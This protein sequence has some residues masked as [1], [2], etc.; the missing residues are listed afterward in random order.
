MGINGPGSACGDDF[1]GRARFTGCGGEG[2]RSEPGFCRRVGR[3]Q[4]AAEERTLKRTSSPCSIRV[5]SLCRDF[6]SAFKLNRPIKK[7]CL[8]FF[9]SGEYDASWACSSKSMAIGSVSR[10]GEHAFSAR[11]QSQR[12]TTPAISGTAP[13]NRACLFRRA[14]HAKKSRRRALRV[15]GRDPICNP[16]QRS[17]L[18][19]QRC[20]DSARSAQKR[21]RE[22]RRPA[23]RA[24]SLNSNLRQVGQI[25]FWRVIRICPQIETRTVRTLSTDHVNF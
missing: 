18:T 16:Q 23:K 24:T 3:V 4:G 17:S 9:S 12:R 19:I 8:Y 6:S 25:I 22:A 10:R 11:C 1:G 20:A 7:I 2:C 21:A 5:S 13:V 15:A 14:P